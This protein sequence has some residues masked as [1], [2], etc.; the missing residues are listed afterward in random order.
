MAIM[1]VA[2]PSAATPPET[3][4]ARFQRLAATWEKAVA[5]HSSS[6]IREDHPAYLEIA[7]MGPAV[8]P[9]LLRDMEANETHWFAAL[10]RI[11][12]ANPVPAA[13][14]GNIPRMIAAWLSW[15]R[16]NGHRW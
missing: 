5:Y 2:R 13:D 8:V 16:E 3:V 6:T 15:A 7:T 10:Q 11:T 12:G 1:P 14:T 4:E 9:L